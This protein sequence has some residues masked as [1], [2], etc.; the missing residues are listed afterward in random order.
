MIKF[1]KNN[2]PE[3]NLYKK[4]TIKSELV[5]QMIYGES[6]LILKRFNK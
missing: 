1:Y 3:I 4:K 5:T 2:Y 6:F